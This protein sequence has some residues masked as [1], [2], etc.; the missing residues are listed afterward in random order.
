MARSRSSGPDKPLLRNIAIEGP[1][2][3]G[4]TTLARKLAQALGG[5]RLLL[6]RPN[7]IPFLESFY[8]D[9]RKM[10]LATQLSF[11]LQRVRM[12][13]DMQRDDMFDQVCVSDFMIERDRLFAEVNLNAEEFRLYDEIHCQLMTTTPVIP[14]RVVYLQAPPSVLMQR[15]RKRNAPGEQAVASDYLEAIS[16]AYGHFFL[17]Y[18]AAPVLIIDTAL[19]DFI[20]NPEEFKLFLQKLHEIDS[21]HHFFNTS[22]I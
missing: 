19:V 13:Q 8:R 21:G 16:A 12:L 5:A 20:N 10:A 6:E 2:G 3:V 18:T 11:L 9:R 4:K 22:L 1:I 15:V 7:E 14:D 17:H